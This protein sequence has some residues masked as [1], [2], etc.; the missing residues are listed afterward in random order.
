MSA[1]GAWRLEYHFHALHGVHFI[2]FRAFE[3][4]AFTQ[5]HSVSVICVV[6][7]TAFLLGFLL[8]IGARTTKWLRKIHRPGDN[9]SH[10][11]SRRC[12]GILV[13]LIRR[14]STRRSNQ[15]GTMVPYSS[16]KSMV[17]ILFIS[18]RRLPNLVQTSTQR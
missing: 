11:L 8:A 9:P 13:Q 15:V 1:V 3:F 7:V 10:C 17:C 6:S 2:V 12:G 5:A 18:S 4:A 16:C 14:K